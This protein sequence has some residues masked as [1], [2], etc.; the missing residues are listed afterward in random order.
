MSKHKFI[1]LL[2]RVGVAFAFLYPPIS[3][4]FDPFAWIGYFPPFILDLPVEPKLIL[5]AFGVFE[6][7]IALW[8]LFGKNIVIP[9]ALAALSLLGIVLFNIPQMDVLF[10]DLSIAA[11]ALALAVF[12]AHAREG[13]SKDIPALSG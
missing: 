5:N 12:N 2:L 11:M 10:R 4:F 8:I 6:I 9:C 1:D 7:A 13:S 3:A